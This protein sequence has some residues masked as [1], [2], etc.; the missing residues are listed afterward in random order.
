VTDEIRG[1]SVGESEK[2]SRV[3]L[4][5]V[6]DEL[7]TAG[8]KGFSL[9]RR[10]R[11]ENA[12]PARIL[13]RQVQSVPFS[14]RPDF[15]SRRVLFAFVSSAS[16]ANLEDALVLESLGRGIIAEQYHS[17]S[18]QTSRELRDPGSG[19]YTHQSDVVVVAVAPAAPSRDADPTVAIGKSE[20]DAFLDSL[21]EDLRALRAR[22]DALL[23][24]HNFMAPEF[25]TLG[26][27][28]WRERDGTSAV[29]ARLNLDL[30]ERCREIPDTPRNRRVRVRSPAHSWSGDRRRLLSRLAHA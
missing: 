22:S 11:S 2:A 5:D 28:D 1:A 16:L 30:V 8:W 13:A 27:H 23:L 25:R 24:V 6:L 17:A 10:Y 4:Q 3:S 19:L 26:V 20:A 29:Y 15:E 7:R 21:V 9:L 18:R 12:T 14:A